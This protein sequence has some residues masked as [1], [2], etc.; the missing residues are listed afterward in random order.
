MVKFHRKQ[1]AEKTHASD[2]PPKN[3]AGENWGSLVI[4]PLRKT[5]PHEVGNLDLRG[6][7][8]ARLA[9]PIAVNVAQVM[10]ASKK[11]ESGA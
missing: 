11:L 10:V 2:L 6:S 7:V 3:S 4:D 9:G 5:L 8:C 1:G